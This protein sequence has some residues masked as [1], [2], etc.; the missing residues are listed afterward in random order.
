MDVSRYNFASQKSLYQ[1]LRYARSFGHQYLE[2]EHIAIAILHTEAIK[3]PRGVNAKL[4][5]RLQREL[6]KNV[7]VLGEVQIEFGQRLDLAL[8]DAESIAGKET[9]DVE[10]LWRCLKLHSQI[11][12]SFFSGG[13]DGLPSKARAP[14]PPS[15]AKF[16]P[17]SAPRVA[18]R[19]NANTSEV[20]KKASDGKANSGEATPVDKQNA[21]VLEQY[22]LD[23]TALAERGELDPVLGRD[24]E[25][26]RVLE[27][28]GRKKKNNPILIGEPGVGKTAI[29]E[30]LAMKIADGLVPQ[31]MQEK[32]VL[33]LDLGSLIAGAKFRGEFE[34]RMKRLISAIR[35]YK[36]KIILFI[37][38]MHMIVG[39]GASEGSADAANLLKPP[40]ARGELRCLG[41]TTLD[42]FRNHIEK[43]PAL[44]RRFQ[45]VMVKE[46]SRNATLAILR[47]IKSRYEIHHGVQINDEA[48]VQCSDLSIRYLPS[49]RLP[50]KAID[51]LDEACSRLRLQIDSLPTV[52][53]D[54]RSKIEHLEIEKQALDHKDQ[55]AHTALETIAN[56]LMK[57]QTDYRQLESVWRSHKVGLDTLSNLESQKQE[58]EHLY[59]NTKQKGDFDFA[60]KLQYEQLPKIATELEKQ[61]QYLAKLKKENS[62]LGQIVSGPEIAEVIESWTGIPVQRLLKGQSEALSTMDDRLKDRVFG[63]DEAISKLSKAVKRA[64]V[65]V[66]D[67]NRPL[68]VF[69]F[70]GPTGVGKTETVKALAAELFDDETRMVRIDMSEYME[71]HNVSRLIGSP[72]GYIGHGD[73]GE[74]TEAVRRN[75]YMVVLFD[76]IEKAHPKVLDICLQLFDDGRLTDNNGRVVNFKNTLVVMTS[77]LATTMTCDENDPHFDDELRSQVAKQLRPELVGRIDEVIRFQPLAREHFE[78]LLCQQLDSINARIEE[79]GLN[80]ALGS[81]LSKELIDH[82]S[83]GKFGGRALR[84]TFQSVVID[85]VADF[86][87]TREDSAKGEWNLEREATGSLRWEQKTGKI[88]VIYYVT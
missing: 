82:A 64:R 87:L 55:T 62:W 20:E 26:R 71:P 13:D 19:P 73:G 5:E 31:P 53:D 88:S 14:S 28:L 3:L 24:L 34:E 22:T 29:A 45:A 39:A 54:L 23:L 75:P 74:L 46:P 12:Q 80:V 37:D 60:A 8:E 41:A 52:L 63:Q 16:K 69:L 21:K 79:K 50:D 9:V 47:G 61:R 25:T 49:R 6:A 17:S 56:E 43:D 57:A 7:R 38:E 51:L 67:P 65:G 86:L 11:L 42:E 58:L 2:V 77:N 36:G 40:L 44:E 70:L 18:A 15:R 27:I 30:C 59:E 33:S 66:S 10:L 72:P 83:E 4:Q 84:R 35:A 81:R 78:S 85:A 68:G 1:G 76:E 48:L 32:R